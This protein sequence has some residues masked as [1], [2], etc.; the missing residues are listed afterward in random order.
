[1]HELGETRRRGGKYVNVAG[2]G[3]PRAG[4]QLGRAYNTREEAEAASRVRSIMAGRPTD[5]LT[6]ENE[7]NFGAVIRS[8]SDEEYSDVM[9]RAAGGSK[10]FSATE[11]RRGY[12]KL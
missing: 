9:R 12:R 10:R 2:R 6:P 11:I 4:E 1:M 3:T 7:L 5:I 8:L